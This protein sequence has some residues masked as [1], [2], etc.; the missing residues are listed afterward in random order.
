MSQGGVFLL[1]MALA[2]H[3][4]QAKA[5]AVQR[6][7]T[8]CM[9]QALYYEARSE[10]VRGQEAVAEVVLH[11]ARSGL[12]PKSICGVVHEPGQFSFL[13]DGSMLRQLDLEAWDKAKELA[14]RIVRQEIVTSMTGRALFYHTV[15]VRPDWADS[16]VM[17]AQIGN[18]IFYRQASKQRSS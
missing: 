10:G 3:N 14:V 7:E 16:M 4:Q 8:S 11:R 15:D 9:A 13:G 2:A 12:H 17:T 6:A 1:L 5:E 18:H